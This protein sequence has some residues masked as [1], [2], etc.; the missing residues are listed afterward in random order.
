M[1]RLIKRSPPIT[2]A[3]FF[4]KIELNSIGLCQ[5]HNIGFRSATCLARRDGHSHDYRHLPTKSYLAAL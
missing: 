2:S 4:A 5:Q 1:L 3:N